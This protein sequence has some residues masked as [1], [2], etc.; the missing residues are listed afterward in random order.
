MTYIFTIPSVSESQRNCSGKVVALE[1][2]YEARYTDIGHQKKLFY[3]LS[4]T[5]SSQYF[6]V[7]HKF[8]VEVMPTESSCTPDIPDHPVIHICCERHALRSPN[9]IFIPS[10]AY[11]FGIVDADLKLLMFTSSETEFNFPQILL[12][13]GI[14]GPSV[15]KIFEIPQLSDG[16]LLLLKFL[17][18]K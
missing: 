8:P 14:E 18:G 7:G 3:F 12:S 15:G 6:R 11:S 5:K 1:Y 9:G 13:F 16:S 10:S 4:L 17:I 2:C